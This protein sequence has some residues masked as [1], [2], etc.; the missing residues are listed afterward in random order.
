MA[1]DNKSGLR[2][3]SPGGPDILA[4]VRYAVQNE[5]CMTVSDFMLRRSAVG[6]RKDLGMDTVPAVAAEMQ[7]LLGWSDGEKER[8][9]KEHDS[10]ASL[11]RRFKNP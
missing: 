6:L 11:A 8:Q 1:G 4:Q 7:K 2:P 9:V 10:D 3:L 5:I